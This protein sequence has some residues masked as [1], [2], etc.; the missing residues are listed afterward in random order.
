[1]DINKADIDRL[2]NLGD[3]VFEKKLQQALDAA[4]AS[5]DTVKKLSANIPQIKKTLKSLSQSDLEALADKLDE[6]AIEN[7]KNKL[8]E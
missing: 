8:S 3:G 5:D 4:G 1:M 7:I 2:T 6:K